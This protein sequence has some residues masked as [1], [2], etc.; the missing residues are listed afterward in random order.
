M[1]EMTAR[2][3]LMLAGD[4]IG[5]EIM[6]EARKVLEAINERQQLNLELDEAL[7]GG[8]AIDAVGKALP[9]ETFA[10]CEAADAILLGAVGGPKWDSLPPAERP[11]AR[12]KGAHLACRER[13]RELKLSKY[14]S[15]AALLLE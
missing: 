10:K 8:A 13:N 14:S 15:H 11:R 9:D 7:L 5:P 12:H 3:V 2:K 1:S 4:G 6:A